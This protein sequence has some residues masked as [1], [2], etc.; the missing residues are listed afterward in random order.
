MHLDKKHLIEIYFRIF[1]PKIPKINWIAKIGFTLIGLG[2]FLLLMQS[3][4][5][6]QNIVFASTFLIILGIVVLRIWMNPYFKTRSMYHKRP[7]DEDMDEWLKEDIHIAVKH[8]ALE[9]LRINESI[10]KPENILIV[11][12]PVF[13]DIPGI[14]PEFILRREGGDETYLYTIWNVQVLVLTDNFISYFACTF[15]WLNMKMLG[16][17][18][19]EYFFEDISSVRNDVGVSDRKFF[20]NPEAG[21]GGY[22]NLKITN[23]SGDYLEVI[24]EIPALRVPSYAITSPDK[25]VSALRIILRNRR[26]G[27]YI[28]EIPPQP[29]HTE[30]QETKQDD[31]DTLQKK[32]YFHQELRDVHK[33]YSDKLAE[34][35]KKGN[36]IRDGKL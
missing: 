29:V 22:K 23:M 21:I 26:T 18:T 20:D 28:E 5:F 16:I 14:K 27:E 4:L 11:P 25:L 12:V 31:S 13:W 3:L 10:L 32:K 33:E 8:K 24:T 30:T 34:E 17:K 6:F 19:N 35:R 7:F 2:F 9:F 36:D 15:D 1:H